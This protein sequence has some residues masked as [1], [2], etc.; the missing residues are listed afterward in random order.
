MALSIPQVPHS[1]RTRGGREDQ[2]ALGQMAGEAINELRVHRLNKRLAELESATTPDANAI[3]SVKAKIDRL[4]GIT[5]EDKREEALQIAQVEEAQTRATSASETLEHRRQM[6]PIE[7]G[8][9]RDEAGAARAAEAHREQLRPSDAAAAATAA[10]TGAFKLERLQ[11][12]AKEADRRRDATRSALAKL[13]EGD[14]KGM[15]AVLNK[16]KSIAT[17]A[18]VWDAD[19]EF[20]ISAGKTYADIRKLVLAGSGAGNF[21]PGDM[22]KVVRDGAVTGLSILGGIGQR[23]GTIRG[24]TPEQR[25]PAM[26]DTFTRMAE[27][28]PPG[29]QEVFK[30]I[31]AVWLECDRGGE[32]DAGDQIISNAE[33]A[34]FERYL[35][36]RVN[37]LTSDIDLVKHALRG[38]VGGAA[39]LFAP[40]GQ[41]E[42]GYAAPEFGRGAAPARGGRSGGRAGAADRQTA[43]LDEQLGL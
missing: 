18:E 26:A 42:S 8:A 13:P 19:P 5:A 1:Q 38:T 37:D 34:A 30:E 9:A 7:L 11:L 20:A 16:Y 25:F 21:K 2:R 39:S 6:R 3:A 29:A 4:K 12:D 32:N 43:V 33:L 41:D 36:V 27:E 24:M 31:Y 15:E 35:Q 17:S 23:M 40:P 28:A 14:A 22:V 10:E